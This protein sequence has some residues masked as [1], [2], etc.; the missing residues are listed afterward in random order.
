MALTLYKTSGLEDY[1]LA[2]WHGRIVADGEIANFSIGMERLSRFLQ[3]FQEPTTLVYDADE[4]INFAMWFEPQS[5]TAAWVHVYI[6]P[7]LRPTKRAL[8]NVYEALAVGLE[9]YQVLIATTRSVAI[10]KEHEKVG[11]TKLGVVPYASDGEPMHVSFL[12]REAFRPKK[13]R[14]G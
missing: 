11:F 14:R 8:A 2:R 12:T 4:D 13:V 3:W 6:A 7:H 10:A 9:L 1:K 5:A